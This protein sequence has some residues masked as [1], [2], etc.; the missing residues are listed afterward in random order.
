[1]LVIAAS[2]DKDVAGIAAALAPAVSA[3]VATRYQQDRAMDPHALAGL[4]GT[5]HVAPDLPSALA[6]AR[7]LGSEVVV[8]GSLF[9]VGEARVLLLG[10]P[11]DPVPA[12]EKFAPG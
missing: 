11:A 9:L 7:T 4:F 2:A 8:A 12:A 10:A 3:V 1:M 6:L 5:P